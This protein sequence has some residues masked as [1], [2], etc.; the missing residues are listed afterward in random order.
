MANDKSH[1]EQYI[2]STASSAWH[3]EYVAGYTLDKTAL[4]ISIHFSVASLHITYE[5]LAQCERD[6]NKFVN[7]YIAYHIEH[8][9]SK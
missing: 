1:V 3:I 6:Y 2:G 9:D 4:R 7:D 8:H 5:N